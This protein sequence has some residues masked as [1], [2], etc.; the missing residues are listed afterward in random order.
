L[1]IAA[2]RR[3]YYY[4]AWGAVDT[5]LAAFFPCPTRPNPTQTQPNTKTLN[6]QKVLG[7]LKGVVAA[8]VSV[9]L[10]RNAVTGRGM[11]GYAVTIAGVFLYS[12]SK[13]R[14]AAHRAAE[15]ARA[16]DVDFAAPLI[17]GGASSNAS[18]AGGAPPHVISLTA[19]GCAVS[20]GGYLPT[21][22]QQLQQHRNA[23]SS[24]GVGITVGA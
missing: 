22:T 12:A 1:L 2:G 21:S 10:F 19:D 11:A 6:Q 8:A 9:A 14:A 4:A 23:R 3:V 7:N 18:S 15:A 5:Q 20:A 17:K 16:V 24:G 13:R